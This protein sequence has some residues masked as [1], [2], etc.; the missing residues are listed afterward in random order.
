MYAAD[1]F[2]G[3]FAKDPL[4]PKVGRRWRREVLE[5][6]AGQSELDVME[7]FLGRPLNGDTISELCFQAV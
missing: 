5:C 6:A 3:A 4:D 7:R 1:L 2:Q